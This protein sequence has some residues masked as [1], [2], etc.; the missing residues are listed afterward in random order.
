MNKEIVFDLDGVMRDLLGYIC[1]KF[2]ALPPD[3]WDW[4]HNNK[5]IF[6][7]I[8]EDDY[9]ALVDSHTTEYF[10]TIKKF[11]EA[12][13][14]WTDQPER[15]KKRTSLWL[16]N[17]LDTY[18]IKYLNNKEKRERLDEYKDTWLVEDSPNFT[19]YER[20]ILIDKT[21]NQDVDC[22]IRIKT[23]MELNFILNGIA[24]DK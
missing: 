18:T 17:H 4:K 10:S 2:S 20:I 23:L 5:N 9:R 15:W 8:K 24:N 19:N 1:Y 7:L 11:T 16:D 12:P 14:I 3:K 13:E 21:Y 22:P 6:Q